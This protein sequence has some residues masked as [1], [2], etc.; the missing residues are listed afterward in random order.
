LDFCNCLV[1]G[2]ANKT[3]ECRH[4]IAASHCSV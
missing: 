1:I 4:V 3:T 2:A